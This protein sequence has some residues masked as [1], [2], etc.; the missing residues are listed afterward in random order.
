M[1]DKLIRDVFIEDVPDWE[2]LEPKIRKWL[3]SPGV[4]LVIM[5]D[6]IFQHIYERL[7]D[8]ETEDDEEEDEGRNDTQ[9]RK[10]DPGNRAMNMAFRIIDG[11]IENLPVDAV[12]CKRL[13]DYI[14]DIASFNAYD[15]LLT[16]YRHLLSEPTRQRVLT[17]GKRWFIPEVTQDWE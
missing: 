10:E 14:Q 8:K 3:A 12:N 15:R 4:G 17:E 16:D 13:L 7:L 11:L 2:T 9:S 1:Q 6:W 5:R